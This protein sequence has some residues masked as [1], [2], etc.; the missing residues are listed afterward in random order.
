MDETYKFADY[1]IRRTM[2]EQIVFL[3]TASSQYYVASGIGLDICKQ[4]DR[5]LSFDRITTHICE[6]FDI[7]RETAT[8]DA[9]SFFSSLESAGIIIKSRS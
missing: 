2:A 4:I 1:T 9:I 6:T 8:K 3:Q 7:D 5:G